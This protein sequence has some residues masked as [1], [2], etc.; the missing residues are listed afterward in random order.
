MIRRSMFRDSYTDLLRHMITNTYG[1]ENNI[2]LNNNNVLPPTYAVS[3]SLTNSIYCDTQD[4]QR[5]HHTFFPET[6][7]RPGVTYFIFPTFDLI[8]EMK[9]TVYISIE[10][11]RMN[12][13]SCTVQNVNL[14]AD[15][16]TKTNTNGV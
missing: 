6:H 3:H 14:P 9:G 12:H 11:S 15:S 16:T 13:C 8:I 2:S 5:S 10:G 1:P 4:F 7:G